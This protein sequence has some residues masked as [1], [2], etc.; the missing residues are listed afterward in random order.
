[1]R[2][3]CYVERFPNLRP[4]I[5]SAFA[6]ESASGR[7]FLEAWRF[8]EVITVCSGIAEV[9]E[10]MC[11]RLPNQMALN[12][13]CAPM[14][15]P[16]IHTWLKLKTGGYA[17]DIGFIH[18]LHRDF[19]SVDVVVVPRIHYNPTKS[20]NPQDRA[21]LNVIKALASGAS[22]V[23]RNGLYFYHGWAF[24]ACGY[25][26]LRQRTP[27]DYYYGDILP[28]VADLKHFQ[29]CQA[30]PQEIFQRYISFVSARA[31]SLVLGDCV[32]VF[33]GD[34]QNLVGL[35]KSLGEDHARIALNNKELC[36]NPIPLHSLRKSIKKGD[37]VIITSGPN[38]GVTGYVAGMK[39]KEIE[40]LVKCPADV[41][42]F[43]F[44]NM[45]SAEF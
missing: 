29:A 5:R 7:I 11:K 4:M 27:L 32:R 19:L 17:N 38:Q 44:Q 15:V 25:I 35:V 39:L 26:I 14:F 40:I 33:S 23:K 42:F 34:L 24:T 21:P 41:F 37:E 6:H 36:P 20:R 43:F 3:L 31:A 12:R 30:I 28:T 22:L 18:D 45:Y 13:L 9:E 8:C 2:I 16:K 10:T 1:M